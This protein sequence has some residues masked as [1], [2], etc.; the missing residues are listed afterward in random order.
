MKEVMIRIEDRISEA[1]A[2]DAQ[3]RGVPMAELLRGV[4]GDYVSTHLMLAEKLAS[5]LH[6]S[7]KDLDKVFE[8]LERKMLKMRARDGALT[9]K[10]CTMRLTEKDVDNRKCGSCGA[11][12]GEFLGER[13][14]DKD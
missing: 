14:E 5:I 1:L 12:L 13:E 9:C 4:I 2:K 7:L 8:G 6:S 10:D 3:D 11:P